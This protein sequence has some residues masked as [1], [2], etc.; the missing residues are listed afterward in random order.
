MTRPAYL[1]RPPAGC[2]AVA[3]CPRPRTSAFARQRRI[4]APLPSGSGQ[5]LPLPFL[6]LLALV[7]LLALLGHAYHPASRLGQVNYMLTSRRQHM[8][9]RPRVWMRFDDGLQRPR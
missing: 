8:I 5:L 6:A 1:C 7:G 3:R 9:E 4:A 2:E